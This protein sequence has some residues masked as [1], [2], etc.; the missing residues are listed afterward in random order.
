[1][2]Y[3]GC[4]KDYAQVIQNLFSAVSADNIT[5]I[6]LGTLRFPPAL[7]TIIE[8]RFPESKIIYEEFIT[9]SDGKM[10]Y[11]KPLRIRLYRKIIEIIRELAPDVL[12]YLCMEDD[13]VWKESLGFKPSAVGGLAHMLDMS[14][15]KHCHLETAP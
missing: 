10:R 12:V 8:N 9:G 3:D 2:I 11:F 15:I 1:M 14:A 5:W 13:E 7:K 4:E 6:S